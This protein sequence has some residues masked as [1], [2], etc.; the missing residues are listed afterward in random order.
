MRGRALSCP[1]VL[2]SIELPLLRDCQEGPCRRIHS[3][4]KAVAGTET[5]LSS[6]HEKGDTVQEE[7][8]SRQ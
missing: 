2:A 3:P 8:E 5:R 6:H 7:C 4:S 1:V